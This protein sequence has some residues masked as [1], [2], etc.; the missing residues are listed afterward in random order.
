MRSYPH[1]FCI[2]WSSSLCLLIFLLPLSSPPHLWH[3]LDYFTHPRIFQC[4]VFP[5]RNFL[6]FCIISTT[7]WLEFT[8]SSHYIQLYSFSNNYCL[9]IHTMCRYQ[10]KITLCSSSWQSKLK[11]ARFCMP[12]NWI[13][14]IKSKCKTIRAF[15]LKILAWK[16][17]IPE[18][19]CDLCLLYIIPY[20]NLCTL[21]M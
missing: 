19:L 13:S 5:S 21:W 4:T 3:L 20:I 17:L 16:S 8:L 9:P 14:K 10:Q 11:S 6:C 1:I 2:P 12:S 7:F 18:V 15:L